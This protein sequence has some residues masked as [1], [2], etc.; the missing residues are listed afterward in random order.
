MG[1]GWVSQLT[2][3]SKYRKSKLKFSFI[4]EKIESSQVLA[5]GWTGM[6]WTCLLWGLVSQ[7]HASLTNCQ[8]KLLGHSSYF[9]HMY[10]VIVKNNCQK[11]RDMFEWCFQE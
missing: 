10:I 3:I 2:N 6:L 5:I 9:I 4:Y 7:M 11:P 1:A 8:N